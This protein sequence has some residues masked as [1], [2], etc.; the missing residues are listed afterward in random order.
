VRRKR[1]EQEMEKREKER[2]KLLNKYLGSEFSLN[3]FCFSV[4]LWAKR[5]RRE[6]PCH[7]K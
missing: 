5:H 6:K 3:L 4:E 2:E 1:R 7:R